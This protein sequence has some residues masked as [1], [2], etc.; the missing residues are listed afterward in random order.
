VIHQL[1]THPAD[2]T[3]DY[4]QWF[5]I[6]C[7]L[8]NEFGESGRDY[9]HQ[10]SQYYPGYD[11]PETDHLFDN[12]LTK[13]Y[14]YG[15]GTFFMYAQKAGFM[16]TRLAKTAQAA[17]PQP[18]VTT[19]RVASTSPDP[20]SRPLIVR[21][22]ADQMAR[23]GSILK[24]YKSQLER[25]TV[26]ISEATYPTEWDT[27]S[28]VEKSPETAFEPPC[29]NEANANSPGP[30]PCKSAYYF[31]QWQQQH[32]YYGRHGVASLMPDPRWLHG[33]HFRFL[34]SAEQYDF[35]PLESER[36]PIT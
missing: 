33:H 11:L 32:P 18:S 23:P 34:R 30:K 9:F 28:V 10:V 6:G 14:R 19:A 36:C 26:P 4:H 27:A 8:A 29:P 13:Q 25:D 20:P 2:I 35:H 12:A 22:V 3:G 24:P 1:R 15:I 31:H 17:A 21:T 16:P 5:E 7:A